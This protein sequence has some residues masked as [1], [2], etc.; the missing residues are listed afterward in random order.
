MKTIFTVIVCAILMASCG[1]QASDQL[2]QVQRQEVGKSG[3][4]KAEKMNGV[5]FTAKYHIQ[6]PFLD[7]SNGT[8]ALAKGKP[9]AA[10][11]ALSVTEDLV[12]SGSV[13]CSVSAN[14]QW[15]GIQKFLA[16]PLSND[17]AVSYCNFYWSRTGTDLP[18]PMVCPTTTPGVYRGWTSDAAASDTPYDVHLSPTVTL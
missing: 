4:P 14:A 11:A 9:K 16:I 10:A 5:E 17:G 12:I 3:S 18:V 13:E 15:G 6:L 8:D 2:A 7:Y 1:K